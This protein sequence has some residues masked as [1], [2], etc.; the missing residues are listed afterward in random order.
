MLP[1][2]NGSAL[3]VTEYVLGVLEPHELL[4]ATETVPPVA[5]TVVVIEFELELPLHPDGNNHVYE[6]APVTA[7]ILYV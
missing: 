4:A 5:P 3:T 1:G 2:C 6:V 7:E